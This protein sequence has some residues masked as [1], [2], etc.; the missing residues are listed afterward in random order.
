[1]P[2]GKGPIWLES[3]NAR[4]AIYP[5]YDNGDGWIP[6]ISNDRDIKLCDDI[7]AIPGVE[8]VTSCGA[9]GY[10]IV[11]EAANLNKLPNAVDRVKRE[12]YRLFEEYRV[13]SV[14][15]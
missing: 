3:G 5:E 1:M 14:R 6:D 9:Q 12:V 15:S 2:K 4:A 8:E 13:N 10:H 7:M 11:V